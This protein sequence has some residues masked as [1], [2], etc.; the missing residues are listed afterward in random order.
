MSPNL[1]PRENAAMVRW[2]TFRR[3]GP[4]G[5]DLGSRSVKLVQLSAD[6]SE[7]RQAV[8]WELPWREQ[9][10]PLDELARA[11]QEA[12]EQMRQSYNFRS[13][14][15][16][17]SLSAE[18]LTLQNVRI[19]KLAGPDLDRA[20][21]QEVAGKL[22]YPIEEAE[23]RCWQAGDVRQGEAVKREVIVLACHRPVLVRL[24]AAIEGAGLEPVAV[25]AEPAALVRCYLKQFRRD[26]DRE[27]RT[28][29]VHVGAGTT[30]VVI[31][32]GAEVL[33]AKYLEIGGRHFDEAVSRNLKMPLPDASA[34]RRN[35]GDRR[36]DQQDPEVTRGVSEAIRPVVEQL[37]G[38]LSRC[39]RYYVV[40]FRSQP[41]SRLVLG[42]GEATGS[43]A[44]VLTSRLD[45]KCELGDPLRSYEARLPAARKGVW[46][47]ACGLA[48]REVP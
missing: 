8:R 35:N 26:E 34:L 21:R 1:A 41:A 29:Y 28:M 2:T 20:V 18:Q 47:V 37:A 46:D 32:R 23:L 9:R 11:W 13:R 14:E 7:L 12:I 48:L 38:E 30:T 6:R 16:V 27:L 10:P 15:A 17:L 44:E 5:V 40:T 31:A 3:A 19:S 4:I 22:P 42:G 43:L 25:D 24:L 39:L 45:L 33:F 36:V